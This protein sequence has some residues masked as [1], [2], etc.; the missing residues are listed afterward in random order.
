MKNPGIKGNANT[1]KLIAELKKLQKQYPT[2][3]KDEEREL[4]EENKHDRIK[5]NQLLVMHNVRAVFNMAKKYVNKTYDFDG[6]V[7][8]G[9]RGL[10]EA[11][12]LFDIEKGTKFI[13]YAMWWIRKRMTAN[14]YGRQTEVDKRTLSLNAKSQSVNGNGDGSQLE[15][16]VNEYIDPSCDSTKSSKSMMSSIEERKI[17]RELFQ[18]VESSSSL[19]AQDKAVFKDIYWNQDRPKDISLK[20]NIS[21]HDIN[22]IKTKVL[23]LCKQVLQ[24]QYKINSYF[25][26][27]DE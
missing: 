1:T 12:S 4:I 16:F 2:L 10:A 21:I 20:Y 25:D 15:N 22:Q 7:M 8:D 3:S 6:L 19:S 18:K 23:G 13:T 9:M 11:A 5:L 24:E 17:C 14:F 26:L 27:H